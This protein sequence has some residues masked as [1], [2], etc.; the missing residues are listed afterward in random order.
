MHSTGVENIMLRFR[1]KEI[2]DK[3]AAAEARRRAV[4]H[5]ALIG[6]FDKAYIV[7]HTLQCNLS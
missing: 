1:N 6:H 4:S 3:L 5:P 2:S 7:P